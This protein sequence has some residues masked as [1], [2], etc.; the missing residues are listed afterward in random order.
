MT[1]L[2]VVKLEVSLKVLALP[3]TSQDNKDKANA[4]IAKVMSEWNSGL[5]LAQ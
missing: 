5:S 1:Q 4:F 2:D 3:D